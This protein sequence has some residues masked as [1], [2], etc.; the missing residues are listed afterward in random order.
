M[1]RSFSF[2]FIYLLSD[3]ILYFSPLSLSLNGTLLIVVDIRK[4]VK[5]PRYK[6]AIGKTNHKKVSRVIIEK[7]LTVN[8]KMISRQ[9]SWGGECV[10]QLRCLDVKRFPT[11]KIISNFETLQMREALHLTSLCIHDILWVDTTIRI[12]WIRKQAYGHFAICSRSNCKVW[13]LGR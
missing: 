7:T 9:C 5:I 13:G 1:S 10:K 11:C 12:W 2:F 4:N 3:C 8:L 6:I